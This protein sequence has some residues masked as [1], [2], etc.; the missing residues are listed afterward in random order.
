MDFMFQGLGKNKDVYSKESQTR[1]VSINNSK[2]NQTVYYNETSQRQLHFQMIL[3]GQC[4]NLVQIE[5]GWQL[6]YVSF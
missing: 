4:Q 2:G 3:E 1:V 6:L 5:S